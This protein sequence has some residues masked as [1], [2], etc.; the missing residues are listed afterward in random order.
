MVRKKRDVE[1]SD[2]DDD[3]DEAP[4]SDSSA[5]ESD[6]DGA[7]TMLREMT[8]PAISGMETSEHQLTLVDDVMPSL[9]IHPLPELDGLYVKYN[10]NSHDL[11]STLV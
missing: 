11:Y 5:S 3:K 7:E 4:G 1:Q 8:P 6:S 9:I 10:Y 2:S